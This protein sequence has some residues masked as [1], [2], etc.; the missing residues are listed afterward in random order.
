MDRVIE[1]IIRILKVLH[2]Y[3][4]AKAFYHWVID[5][6]NKITNRKRLKAFHEAFTDFYS[7]VKQLHA[8]PGAIMVVG[9]LCTPHKPTLIPFLSKLQQLRQKQILLLD[10]ACNSEIQS[11]FPRLCIPRSVPVKFDRNLELSVTEEMEHLLQEKDFLR[12][13]VENLT[14]RISNMTPSYAKV[15]VCETYEMYKFVLDTWKPAEVMIWNEFNV[16]HTICAEV[17]REKGIDPTFLE[18]G[19]LPGTFAME[20]GGQ[21]GKSYVA[22]NA[23]KFLQKPVTEEELEKSREVLAFLRA[24][25]LNRNVQPDNDE[26]ERLWER[27]KPGRPV[28]LFAGQHDFDS[29]LIPYT[30][31][32]RKYHSP[33]FATSLEAANHLAKIAEKN[34]WNFIFKPHPGVATRYTEEMLASNVVFVNKV[35]LNEL[36]DK[37]DVVVTLMSQTA[38]VSLIR[39]R[40][41]VT[42]G[43]N[44]LRGKNCTYEA[45]TEDS[46]EK[47][48]ADA[49]EYGYTAEQKQQFV[50]H[51]AQLLKYYLYDDLKD[52]PLRYGQVL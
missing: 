8:D 11:P 23:E 12:H 17:C 18:F 42:L 27:L 34:D 15:L 49:I 31:E 51:G 7:Q 52:R 9:I 16:L 45:Y 22:R 37:V 33:M 20:Q 30:E 39:E 21:M 10:E 28:V 13:A 24:S 36:I 4:V 2:L 43:Y 50:R 5:T 14:L 47:V 41:V 44:Q 29:G 32:T 19:V 25:G 1:I 26:M 3:P 35:N 40:A 46:I 6:V 38:Y 48:I